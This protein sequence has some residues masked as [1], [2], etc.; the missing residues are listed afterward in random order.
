M[1][2]IVKGSYLIQGKD[3]K[4]DEVAKFVLVLEINQYLMFLVMLR[5]YKNRN[6]QVKL[7][8]PEYHP[9]ETDIQKLR[10]LTIEEMAMLVQSSSW[11]THDFMRL[12]DITANRITLFNGRRGGEPARLLLSEWE[13]AKNDTWLN[14]QYQAKIDDVKRKIFKDTKVTFQG[15]KG[16]NH[17]VPVII[18]KDSYKQWNFWPMMS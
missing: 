17:L 9:L 4:A 8:K 6:R 15:G 5:I 13:E 1:V 2:K 7:R 12:R 3:E 18:P 14:S 16:N 10:E 11:E